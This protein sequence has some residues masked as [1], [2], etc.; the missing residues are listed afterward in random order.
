MRTVVL[1]HAS[2]P[3]PLQVA[4]DRATRV[5]LAEEPQLHPRAFVDRAGR[6]ALVEGHPAGSQMHESEREAFTY[7]GY[8]NLAD[9]SPRNVR[10]LVEIKKRWWAKPSVALTQSPGGIAA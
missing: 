3:D 10:R 2:S 6:V 8:V 7:T 5:L 1:I 9:P 4:V